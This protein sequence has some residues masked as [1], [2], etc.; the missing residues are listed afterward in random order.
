MVPFENLLDGFVQRMES[1]RR[2]SFGV[3][4]IYGETPS[5]E[6]KGC[7]LWRGQ[8][9]LQGLLDHPQF[10]YCKRVKADWENDNDRKRIEDYWGNVN[11]N[12]T[13]DSL[14]VQV[15]RFWK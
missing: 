15:I 4:G 6:I 1:I 3:M 2:Y 9:V 11:D 12:D 13:V 14:T 8:E 5:L 7:L 10:E